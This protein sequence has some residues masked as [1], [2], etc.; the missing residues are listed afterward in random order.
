ML[1][2]ILYPP[3]NKIA[4]ISTPFITANDAAT[5]TSGRSA[6]VTNKLPAL[7]W[8]TIWGKLRA[9]KLTPR[10]RR[11][12]NSPSLMIDACKCFARSIARVAIKSAFHS[13][14]PSSLI[15]LFANKASTSATFCV[16]CWKESKISVKSGRVRPDSSTGALNLLITTPKRLGL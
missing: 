3:V 1:F 16:L 8:S 2:S 9:Q 12:F 15:G 10:I 11:V 14:Q 6:E 4:P 7:K 5:N 13:I